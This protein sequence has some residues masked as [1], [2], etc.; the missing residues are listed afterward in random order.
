MTKSGKHNEATRSYG[1]YKT[2]TAPSDPIMARVSYRI[3]DDCSVAVF[4]QISNITS[5][6][7]PRMTALISL[8]GRIEQISDTRTFLQFDNVQPAQLIETQVSLKLS[9]FSVNSL[10]I[11]FLLFPAL[12]KPN[13]LEINCLPYR[14]NVHQLFKPWLIDYAEFLRQWNRFP[15]AF[16]FRATVDDKA[17]LRGLA[18]KISSYYRC[19]IDWDYAADA[20]FQVLRHASL[21]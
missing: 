16:S 6:V 19:V 1:R 20:Y 4:M 8:R 7:I 14:L 5:I 10:H 3:V 13:T 9:S 21:S 2:I 18:H 12:D 17:Q 15:N 11:R